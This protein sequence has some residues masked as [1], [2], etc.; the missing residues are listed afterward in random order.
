MVGTH[1]FIGKHS[2][3]KLEQLNFLKHEPWFFI[4]L[5]GIFRS[6]ISMF[7]SYYNGY[8]YKVFKNDKW[9]VILE[10]MIYNLSDEEIKN[11]C[12]EIASKFVDNNDFLNAIRQFINI[13]DG[14]FIFRSMISNQINISDLMIILGRL[15]IYYSNDSEIFIISRDI[16]TNLEFGTKIEFDLAGITEFLI[17]GYSLGNKTY[18]RNI[19]KLEPYQALLIEDLSDVKKYNLKDTSEIHYGANKVKTPREETLLKLKDTFLKTQKT[20]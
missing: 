2:N 8:P 7:I 11:R 9:I 16:K 15:P 6:N 13:C 17:L 3:I 4:E 14:D 1:T 18:F 12:E 20:N 19:R 5:T 10:G